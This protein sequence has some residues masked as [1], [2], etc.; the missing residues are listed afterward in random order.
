MCDPIAISIKMVVVD[1]KM[2]LITGER[3]PDFTS[4]SQL[5]FLD[6]IVSFFLLKHIN[7]QCTTDAFNTFVNFSVA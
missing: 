1:D 6:W 5:P 2:S 4:E 7:S 3:T